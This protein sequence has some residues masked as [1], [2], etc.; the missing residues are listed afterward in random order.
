M[1]GLLTWLWA[2]Q[3]YGTPAPPPV[4][5]RVM[6][7]NIH[8]CKGRDGAVRPER[9]AEVIARHSPDLVALQEVR[10]GRVDAEAVDRPELRG[11]G[12]VPPAVGRAPLPPPSV[13]PPR[14]P[15]NSG[16]PAIPFTDQPRLIAQAAG[17][18]SVFYPLVRLRGE[19]Y[20]LAVLSKRPIRIVRAENLPLNPKRPLAERRG[21]LWVELDVGGV[22]VQVLNTHLGLGKKERL[23]QAKALLGPDWLG[24]AR[25]A[26]P[27][28]LVG[29]LNSRPWDPAFKL[30]TRALPE[31]AAAAGLAVPRTWPSLMPVL[32]LDRVLATPGTAAT[33]ARAPNDRQARAASDHLP[34]IVDLE[35]TPPQE[36]SR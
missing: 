19:D 22:R 12:I 28:I 15:S 23:V 31:A 34:L 29:D 20:G 26:A 9:V 21:A 2:A 4:R 17:M 30:L 13:I 25:A 14:E 35:V 6:T 11:R 3:L 1:T 32:R 10:V 27:L 33:E 7:Y 18:Y 8:S 24:S 36:A 16:G 5:L